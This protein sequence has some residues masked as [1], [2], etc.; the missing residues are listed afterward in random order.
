MHVWGARI[1]VRIYVRACAHA[2]MPAFLHACTHRRICFDGRGA[3][4]QMDRLLLRRLYRVS[5]GYA[6]QNQGP[7]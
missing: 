2:C 4:V 7:H 1:Y 6:H 3:F 5:R